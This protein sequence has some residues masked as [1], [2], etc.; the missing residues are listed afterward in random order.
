MFLI[1]FIV[2]IIEYI[3]LIFEWKYQQTAEFT[4]EIILC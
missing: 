1:L 3:E 4:I 2:I